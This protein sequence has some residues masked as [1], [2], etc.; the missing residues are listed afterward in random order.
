MHRELRI[1]HILQIIME[2]S[3]KMTDALRW[4][5]NVRSSEPQEK[6]ELLCQR[7]TKRQ[8]LEK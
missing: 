1:P 3:E 6:R 7:K 4:M 5:K 8:S 2:Y